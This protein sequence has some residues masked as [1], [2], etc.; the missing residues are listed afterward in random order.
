MKNKT[1]YLFI[2]VFSISLLSAAR[3]NKSICGKYATCTEA[4]KQDHKIQK[5][6]TEKEEGAEIM[7]PSIF[8]LNI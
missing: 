7:L 5:P 2:L 8:L 6:V 4:G 3:K 1:I